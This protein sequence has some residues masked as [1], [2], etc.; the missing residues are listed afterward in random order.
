[1]KRI[2]LCLFSAIALLTL[3]AFSLSPAVIIFDD[4]LEQDVAFSFMNPCSGA[5]MDITGH[6][7]FNVHVVDNGQ[8]ANV[9]SHTR[10]NYTATDDDGNSYVGHWTANGHTS[11]PSPNGAYNSNIAYKVHFVGRGGVEGFDLI[12]LGHV[13]ATPSGALVVDR[14]V[15]EVKCD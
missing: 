6:E 9:S 12:I 5:M 1:M 14:S 4:H 10:G 8:K 11:F 2:I 15:N 7:E 3:P 13:T